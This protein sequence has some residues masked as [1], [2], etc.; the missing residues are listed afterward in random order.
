MSKKKQPGRP[1]KPMSEPI[2]ASPENIAAAI[3]AAPPKREED[4][5]FKEPE[6]T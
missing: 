6:A 4:W 5:R 2:D 3:M 1:P